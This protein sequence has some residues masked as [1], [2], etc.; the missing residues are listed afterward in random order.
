MCIEGVFSHI[1]LQL[2]LTYLSHF[3]IAVP[4]DF[5]DNAEL[6]AILDSF[7]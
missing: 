2:L 1:K 4:T 7:Y 6:S 3:S 5:M